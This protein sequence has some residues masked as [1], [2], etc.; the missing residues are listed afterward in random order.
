MVAPQIVRPPPQ[1]LAPAEFDAAAARN[2]R[3]GGGAPAA[4]A[5]P[6]SRLRRPR[7]RSPTP[8]A[9]GRAAAAAAA[10]ATGSQK[11]E[12]RRVMISAESLFA[13]LCASL[14]FP[15]QP[16]EIPSPGHSFRARATKSWASGLYTLASKHK[17]KPREQA[18]SATDR[19][20]SQ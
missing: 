18:L 9:R 14:G 15:Q 7:W 6:V 3:G 8:G 10:A 2:A 11:P 4:A 5:L 1:I 16:E 12:R 13:C 17:P 20:Q 19:D